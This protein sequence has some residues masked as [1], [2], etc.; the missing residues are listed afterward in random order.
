MGAQ[1]Y[2][3]IEILDYV[4]T[5]APPEDSTFGVS[6]R[7][8]AKVL[9]YHPCSMS[10]P[11]N[12]LVR[13]GLL[14][15]RRAP[16]RDG[17]RKQLTYRITEVGRTRLRR[18]TKEVPLISGEMPPPPHPF[19]GRKDELTQLAEF[20]REGGS[21]TFVD[22]APGMG[23]TALMARHLRRVKRG[24]IPFWFTVRSSVSPRQFVSALSHALSFMGVP[25]LAY[26][27][28]LPRPPVPRETAD[29]VARAVN[30]RAL[31]VVVDDIQ[32]AGT[33][34][35]RFLEEFVESLISKM[36][37]QIFFVGQDPPFFD[38]KG[39][40]SHRLTIGGLDR[41]AAHELTDRSGG[42]AERFETVYQST[43]GS[44]LLLQLAVSNP[45]IEADATS[46][47]SAVVRR[48][49][50][51]E[52]RAMLPVVLA[53]EPLPSTFVSGM[54]ILTPNRLTELTRMGILH[55]TLQG[56][57]EVLQV[58]R[59]ALRARVGPSD[60]RDAHLRLA[61]F[62]SRTRR[63]EAVRERFLHLVDGEAWKPAAILL[64]QQERIILRLGYSDTLRNAFR[65]LAA[66]LPTGPSRVRVLEAEANL[67]RAHSDYSEAIAS[68]RRAVAESVD[69]PRT[70]CECLLSIVELHVR[71]RDLDQAEKDL[72]SAR[73][74][75][76]ISRRL[77]AYFALTE[78]R[79]SEAVGDNRLANERYETAFELARRFKHLD[80][81]LE[82]IAAWSRLEERQSGPD[83]ALRLVAAALPEA[84]QANRLDIVFNLLLVRARAYVRTGQESLAETDL[85]LIRAEAEALG[86]V[87]QLAHALSGLAAIAGG[88]GHWSE[89][90]NYA[91]Q[92]STLAE[93]L[94]NDL[95]LGHTL[96][97]LCSIERRQ[98]VEGGKP[99]LSEDA[100]IHGKM[101]VEVLS[102]VAPSDSLILAHGYLAEAY[103][104]RDER[105][106]AVEHYQKAL[107]LADKLEM[108]WLRDALVSDLGERIR[109]L[110]VRS[111]VLAS[112]QATSAHAS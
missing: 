53:N 51:D 88:S 8:L 50:L 6:Q 68:L 38:P 78:G 93:R 61:K 96:G 57:V 46:L 39:I 65:H 28:Q 2:L 9:G 95:V 45:G 12:D 72:A 3:P 75:G 94:G 37:H 31:A 63:P 10:R 70:A 105:A 40:P 34:M 43:L 106:P 76:A 71:L 104:S 55:R 89:A 74:I 100:I 22:G 52:V 17:V 110:P 1:T 87:N 26:Y 44:P 20:S 29:L 18:E 62:Y 101:S 25:Q 60:E 103:A 30:E 91:K 54:R 112:A 79:M 92:A 35:K 77:Q 42:L 13:E 99:E 19:L 85:K 24:R 107:E 14:G 32:M 111:E 109:A 21:V 59:A 80:L 86:Y 108:G 82:S 15:V 33:D 81:A 49:S 56:R 7:E 98:A 36:D 83:V 27:A 66:V 64:S 90:L 69:E 102:R 16:V 47:P 41:A 11:L 67:L 4:E 97:L 23:K 48:L 84:R 73:R 5:H 58:V